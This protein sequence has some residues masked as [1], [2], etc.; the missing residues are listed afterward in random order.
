MFKKDSVGKEGFD[1]LIGTNT[2][3]NGNIESSGS[4]RVDGKV[5]GDLKASGDVFIGDNAVIT[6]NVYASKVHLAGTVEGNINTTSIL[7]IL[8]TAKLFGDIR[9]KSFVVDEGAIFQGK[10]SM[11][12]EPETE[13]PAEKATVKKASRDYKNSSLSDQ[14]Y[15]YKEL[16][17]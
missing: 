15:D 3:F 17:E 14:L 8:S 10:C 12:E 4:V 6:G 5:K 1:T 13:N 2:T 16:K 7:R 9:V 11:I